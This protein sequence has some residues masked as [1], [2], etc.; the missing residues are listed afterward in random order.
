MHVIDPNV[1]CAILKADD[2]GLGGALGGRNFLR[3][4]SIVFER[5]LCLSTGGVARDIPKMPSSVRNIISGFF[6]DS[7][8]ELWNH[9][10]NHRDLTTLSADEQFKD[11]MMAQ[12]ILQAELGVRPR[13]FGA[14]YNRTNGDTISAVE[15][16]GDFVGIW[17][18]EEQS[19]NLSTIS[20]KNLMS[21]EYVLEATR[22][23]NLDQFKLRWASRSTNRPTIIQ[24]HPTAWN[25]SGF[26]E[27]ERCLDWLLMGKVRF[28]TF[29]EAIRINDPFLRSPSRNV[30]AK[31]A[32]RPMSIVTDASADDYLSSL[33]DESFKSLDR[34]FFGT[35]FRVGTQSALRTLS[36]S[37]ILEDLVRYEGYKERPKV[38]DVGCG[39]G[40]WMLAASTLRPD[41]IVQGFDAHPTCL[42][43]AAGVF[44]KIASDG[45]I[46]IDLAKAENL[47]YRDNEFDAAY[48]INALNYMSVCDTLSELWRV[49]RHGADVLLVTQTNSYFLGA[50]SASLTVQNFDGAFG[51]FDVLAS[52]EAR[53]V[54]L[55]RVRT[56]ADVFYAEKLSILCR[57]LGFDVL[58]ERADVLEGQACWRNEAFMEAYVLKKAGRSAGIDQFLGRRK[59]STINIAAAMELV[60]LGL[61]GHL[62][63]FVDDG[64]FGAVDKDVRLYVDAVSGYSDTGAKETEDNTGERDFSR[65]LQILRAGNSGNWGAILDDATA[66]ASSDESFIVSFAKL[67]SEQYEEVLER[68]RGAAR[69]DPRFAYLGAA[70][71]CK[72]QRLEPAMEVATTGFMG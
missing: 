61:G 18:V 25:A 41:A 62:K 26:A 19:T 11:I 15:R 5:G 40:D 69:V 48:C 59:L 55:G 32:P 7:D 16:S 29:E 49:L 8:F 22:Q 39:V 56:F 34:N 6:S 51:R 65:L 23:P 57:I 53:S 54:G 36:R 2:L 35:R 24:F 38:L 67:R 43:L 21:P 68:V 4:M 28:L 42:R 14:P 72:L 30:E 12:S 31:L 47:P 37:G 13:I 3:L 60:R 1:P 9:S 46:R 50:A 45:R 63:K 44:S 64:I 27:F 10:F 33:S 52:H 17:M 70:A 20:V 58:V 71:A 66:T